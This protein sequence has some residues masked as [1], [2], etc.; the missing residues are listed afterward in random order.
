ML[1]RVVLLAA[2]AALFLPSVALADGVIFGFINGGISTPRPTV[3]SNTPAAT[4]TSPRINYVSRSSGPLPGTPGPPTF[5]TPPVVTGGGTPASTS[6]FG[7]ID[8]ATGNA[9]GFGGSNTLGSFVSFDAGGFITIV[10]NAA[11]QTATGGAVAAGTTLFS[12]FFSAPSVMTQINTP[13]G[14]GC[15]LVTNCVY[16][17]QLVG[18][19]QGTVDPSFLAFMNLGSNN[20]NAQGLI[21]TLNFGFNGTSDTTGNFEGGM[22]SVVVPE[23]GTLALFGTGLIG[24][25]G[26]IRRRMNA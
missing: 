8:F 19:V 3:F 9:T 1:K 15:N 4:T 22:L 2:L 14:G 11:F 7:S 24:L 5:G 18:A 12:G 21:I 23:P 6:N 17:Y 13:G 26:L 20:V 16:Q 25:A 10:S